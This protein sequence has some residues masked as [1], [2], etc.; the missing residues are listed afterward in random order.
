MFD[1]VH[2]L[3]IN[4]ITFIKFDLIYIESTSSWNFFSLKNL[5][6]HV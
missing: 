3:I 6:H 5:G 2:K 1:S 4:I